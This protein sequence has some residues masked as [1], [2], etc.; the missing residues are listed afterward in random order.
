MTLPVYD[1]DLYADAV[2]RDPYPVYA[3]LRE[4]GAGG[5]AVAA[6]VYALPRYAEVASVLR[7]PRRFSSAR[8]VSLNERTNRLLVGSTLNSDP[9][10]HDATRASPP[11][12]CCPARWKPSRRA[13]AAPP[14]P[15]WPSW[16]PAAAST[17]SATS[18][19]TCR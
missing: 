10:E 15:W 4:T 16:P 9:P 18:R 8:G 7:Q 5:V 2:I 17:R 1:G 11:S 12:R 19:N 6:Q 13:S 14:T 3:R